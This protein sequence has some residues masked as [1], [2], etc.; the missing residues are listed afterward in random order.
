MNDKNISIA[1]AYDRRGFNEIAETMEDYLPLQLT[2]K[3]IEGMY[4][5]AVSHT[6]MLGRALGFEIT[7]KKTHMD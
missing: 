3:Q 5:Q 6:K 4:A 1:S 7:I 2:K